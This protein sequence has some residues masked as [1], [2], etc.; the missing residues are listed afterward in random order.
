M[1]KETGEKVIK[2][3]E[4]G[5]TIE[6]LKQTTAVIN[7]SPSQDVDVQN[8][9]TEILRLRDFSKTIQVK[10][11]EDAAAATNDLSIIANIKKAV[12]AKHKEFK[13]PIESYLRPINEVFKMLFTFIDESTANYKQKVLAYDA[14]ER[15]KIQEAA[16]IA[17]MEAEAASR[18]A[19]LE[20]K[21][22]PAP[23]VPPAPPPPTHIHA[24]TGSANVMQIRK[25]RVV[26]FHALPDEYKMENSAL[27][28]KVTKAGMPSLAG[29]EF[30]FEPTLRVEAKR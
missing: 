12:T 24:E 14:E 5:L 19:A 28:N 23:A 16:D 11:K 29:V 4:T 9:T 30:Y 10:N 3:D 20:G 26:D 2:E 13:E 27:L 6:P 21:E 22:T 25:Y 15:R 18:K 7:I 8:L 1:V 17:K